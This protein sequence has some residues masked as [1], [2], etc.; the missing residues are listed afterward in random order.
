MS[1]YPF[2]AFVILTLLLFLT[3]CQGSFTHARFIMQKSENDLMKFQ[4]QFYCILFEIP[5]IF[6]FVQKP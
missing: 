4:Q 3:V 5:A 2:F 6:L 1:I